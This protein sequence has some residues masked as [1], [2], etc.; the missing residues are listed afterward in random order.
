MNKLLLKYRPKDSD[1]AK[2][3]ETWANSAYVLEPLYRVINELKGGDSLTASDLDK[4]NLHERI[5]WN[6]S[7]KAICNQIL[8]M[9]PIDK[10]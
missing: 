3:K 10:V 7:K 8:A 9:L 4:P 2:W 6:E 1:E 5:L